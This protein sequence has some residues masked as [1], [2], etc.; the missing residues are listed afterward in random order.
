MGLTD[1]CLVSRPICEPNFSKVLHWLFV[2]SYFLYVHLSLTREVVGQTFARYLR[3]AV[4]KK[5]N[6]VARED[7]C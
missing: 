1:F 3:P 2:L 4:L 6:L 5:V 7:T